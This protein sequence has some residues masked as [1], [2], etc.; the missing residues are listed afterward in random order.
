MKEG[1]FKEEKYPIKM[2][3]V[4]TLLSAITNG[5]VMPMISRTVDE[6][7]GRADSKKKEPKGI[8]VNSK[9]C[10]IIK[11]WKFNKIAWY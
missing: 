8:N 6:Q 11:I 2:K 4:K 5:E 1:L 10:R 3:A 7:Q 9:M